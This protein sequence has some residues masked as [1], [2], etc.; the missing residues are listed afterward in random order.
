MDTQHSDGAEREERLD[1]A[2][3]AYLKA[4]EAGSTP[5]RAEWLARYPELADFFEAQD[6][7]ARLA[8]PLCAFPPE[9][10]AAAPEAETLAP[11]GPA[12]ADGPSGELRP[13]GDYE[14]L[15]EVARGGMGVVYR[16]R[17]VSLNRTV[18]LKMILAGQLASAD[19]V[20]RFRREART[21]AALQH[22]NIVAI[23]EVGEHGGQHYFSMDYV[24]G[25]NL[26]ELTREHPLPPAQAARYVR[27]VALAVAYAHEHGTLHRDLKPANVLIDAFDQPRVTDFGL[28]RS[29]AADQRLTATGAVVGTPSYMPPEQASADRG[30]LG[31]ASDVYALGAVLYELVTGRPPFQAATPLDTLFQVLHDEPAAPRLL[32]PQVGRDLETILLKCLAKEPSRRYPTAQALADDLGAFLEGRPIQARRPGMAERAWRWAWRQRRSGLLAGAGAAAAVVL[33][34]GVLLG[35]TWYADW[36]LARVSIGTAGP[37]WLEGVAVDERDDAVVAHFTVPTQVPLTLPPGSYRVQLGREGQP[38]ETY[39]LFTQAHG[40]YDFRT[41]SVDRQL[42]EAPADPQG[43]SQVVWLDGKPDVVQITQQGLRRLDGATGNPVWEADL[44]S[45]RAEDLQKGYPGPMLLQSDMPPDGS[46][47]AAGLQC[48]PD[49]DGD[50]A[51]DL[52]VA[53]RSACGLLA[54][55]G[56]T[57][58]ALWWFGAHPDLPEGVKEDQIV[59]RICSGTVIGEPIV[60]DLP[61]DRTLAIITTF[62]GR[63]FLSLKDPPPHAENS[64]VRLW[65]EAV[66]AKGKSLWRHSLDAPPFRDTSWET[67]Y[68]AAVV[69]FHGKPVVVIAIRVA[70][71]LSGGDG[72]GEH[73]VTSQ[74]RLLGL[75]LR[76]GKSVWPDHEL[77]PDLSRRPPAFADL[78]GS[79]HADA[80]LFERSAAPG[81]GLEALSLETRKPFWQAPAGPGWRFVC[82]DP[83]PVIAVVQRGGKPEL[84]TFYGAGPFEARLKLSD[85]VPGQPR[86]RAVAGGQ[87]EALLALHDAA[88]GELR[89]SRRLGSLQSV[90]TEDREHQENYPRSVVVGPDL[91]GDGYRELFVATFSPNRDNPV[92]RHGS[93]YV[94]ALSGR[95][96]H[97]LWWSQVDPAT[98]A[99]R[100]GPLSWGPPGPDGWPLLLVQCTDGR[101]PGLFSWQTYAL[102]ARTGRVQAQMPGFRVLVVADFDRDGLA[103]LCGTVERGTKLRVFRGT[104]P[105]LWRLLGNGWQAVPDLDNDG[106]ADVIDANDRE[107]TTALSGTDGHLLWSADVGGLVK[108]V[109]PLPDGDLDGDGVPDILVVHQPASQAIASTPSLRALSGR[110]GQQLWS[111]PI[112]TPL[113]ERVAFVNERT[114]YLR[115]HRFSAQEQ[116][117]VL[118]GYNT[119]AGD[120]ATA[121]S[122]RMVRISG[123]SGRAVW[124]GTL[125][126]SAAPEQGKVRFPGVELQPVLADLN[127]DGVLDLVLWVEI[128]E[129]ASPGWSSVSWSTR[130]SMRGGMGQGAEGPGWSSVS[131]SIR[132]ALDTAGEEASADWVSRAHQLRAFSGKDGKLLWKGPSSADIS[133]PLDAAFALPVP[134]LLHGERVPQVVTATYGVDKNAPGGQRSF[135]DVLVLNGTDGELQWQWSGDDALGIT[136]ASDWREASPKLVR[137]ATGSDVC[138]SIHDAKLPPKVDPNTGLTRS[139]NQLVLL[140]AARRQVLQRRDLAGYQLTRPRFWVQDLDGD[141]NDEVLFFEKAALYAL[142]DGLKDW[143]SWEL[144]AQDWSLLRIEPA[145][146]GQPAT[147]VV[148]SGGSVYGLD[149]TTGHPRWRCEGVHSTDELVPPNDPLAQL[150]PWHQGVVRRPAALLPANDS[151]ALPR[152]MFGG[153]MDSSASTVICRQ[154][155]AIGPDGKYLLPEPWQRPDDHPS[156]DDPRLARPLPWRSLAIVPDNIMW[157]VRGLALL[158]G[159]LILPVWLFRWARRRRSWRL[160]LLP[161]LWLG[162][163]S[164]WGYLAYGINALFL[165][166]PYLVGAIVLGGPPLVLLGFLVRSAIRRRWRTVALL[167]GC[168]VLATLIAAGVWLGIDARNMD[169]AEHYS[170]QGWYAVAQVGVYAWSLLLFC[171]LCGWWLSRVAR[172]LG[173]SLARRLRPA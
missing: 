139:G 24:E 66:T 102:S 107:H 156:P 73:W 54:V 16:A 28:A 9:Q 163:L 5:D 84:I 99:I 40:S 53:S 52:L 142:R 130:V 122:L 57:G 56:K 93:L 151:Q 88:S 60:A 159:V 32:N 168:A 4:V 36:R 83:E 110:T 162:M 132:T 114:L 77:G 164:L 153:P 74:F 44:F 173:S 50:K 134:V 48:V 62:A 3:T 131:R 55:S 160:A 137:L 133:E 81:M 123:R 69:P 105:E 127:G 144:P 128:L 22:P 155:L 21:A 68:A 87:D 108:V 30:K 161:A 91:D 13:F 12:A 1:E 49:L 80:L 70:R 35:W 18:A 10:R 98:S 47:D 125:E 82:P 29:I 6:Q 65:V 38:S 109:T 63:D 46:V 61:G 79:G 51:D 27:A 170:W 31:P 120:A 34:A 37:Y 23:H 90:T 119:T 150:R 143:W 86:R 94:D 145:Q 138:V 2:A 58:K 166:W 64:P 8:A 157:G 135:C 106:I 41:A 140:D 67:P 167:L 148:A 149:G 165:G 89:W 136:S 158:F 25:Q 15:E 59:S 103:D 171:G 121:K 19:D 39:R 169:P 117:D 14:L 71:P 154:A 11:G 111:F 101:E 116:P 85:A 100:F 141:G 115:C 146:H 92:D 26:A 152:V 78:H 42:W 72:A 97:T 76:S 104:Q 45:R 118:L 75:D 96:G 43:A 147:V 17:Q 112:K 7:V 126:E 129:G 33:A 172:W 20:E 113:G 95:D 124:N